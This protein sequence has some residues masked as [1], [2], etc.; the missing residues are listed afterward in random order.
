MHI[1]VNSLKIAR[2]TKQRKLHFGGCLAR[3]FFPPLCVHTQNWS[4]TYKL[5]DQHSVS[6]FQ[7]YEKLLRCDFS[8]WHNILAFGCTI[9]YL[10]FP[11]FLASSGIFAVRVG[12]G[13]VKGKAVLANVHFRV[14]QSGVRIEKSS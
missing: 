12:S 7:C 4:H 2:S 13:L 3:H 5:L 1:V 10:K 11:C 6:I 14:I 8:C 9:I